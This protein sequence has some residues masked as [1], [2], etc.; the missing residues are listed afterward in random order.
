MPTAHHRRG[1]RIWLMQCASRG[2]D[3]RQIRPPA[4]KDWQ[5]GSPRF[6]RDGIWGGSM[7][8]MLR[9]AVGICLLVAMNQQAMA[10][11]LGMPKNLLSSKQHIAFRSP[12][13]AP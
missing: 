13:L 6:A 7:K 8:Q 11:I 4:W 1:E 2:A 9:W 5:D 10:N 12:T 3:L